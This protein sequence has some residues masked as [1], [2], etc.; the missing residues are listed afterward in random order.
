MT[1][2]HLQPTRGLRLKLGQPGSQPHSY[3]PTTLSSG[4][5]ATTGLSS[6]LSDLLAT[7]CFPEKPKRRADS[8]AKNEGLKLVKEV[9]PGKEFGRQVARRG[10]LHGQGANAYTRREVRAA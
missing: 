7:S 8:V 5:R 3:L 1:V 4:I 2:S 6:N 10:S 9:A